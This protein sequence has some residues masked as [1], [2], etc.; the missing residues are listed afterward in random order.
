MFEM[1]VFDYFFIQ[2]NE[3]TST[4]DILTVAIFLDEHC[5]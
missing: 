4:I 5:K 3:P 1:P 2:I